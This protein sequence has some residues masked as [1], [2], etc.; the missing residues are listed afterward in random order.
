MKDTL[1]TLAWKGL[2]FLLGHLSPP[3]SYRGMK[4]RHEWEIEIF[5]KHCQHKNESFQFYPFV[6]CINCQRVLREATSKETER[7]RQAFLK[8]LNQDIDEALKER[9]TV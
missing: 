5:Q 6:I 9:V 1:K 2:R 8:E 4:A 7:E 3:E